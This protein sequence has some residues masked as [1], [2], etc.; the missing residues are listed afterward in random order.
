MGMGH[1][2]KL[3]NSVVMAVAIGKPSLPMLKADVSYRGKLDNGS[4]RQ[5]NMNTYI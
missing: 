5:N 3:T 1:F 2:A 4:I